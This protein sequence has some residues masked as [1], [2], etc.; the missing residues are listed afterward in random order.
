MS[1]YMGID[2]YG[3]TYHGLRHPRKDLLE[4]LGRK[5]ASKM[6]V[7]KLDGSSIHIGYVIAGHWITVY[8]V[9][10]MEKAA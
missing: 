2:Q 5:R 6:Y 8:K 10:R 4:R 7:D 3:N 9:E 1:Q